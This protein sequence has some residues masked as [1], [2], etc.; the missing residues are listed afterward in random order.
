MSLKTIVS[1]FIKT[2]K[3]P[4]AN[5]APIL[6]PLLKPLFSLLATIF[7]FFSNNSLSNLLVKSSTVES[8]ELLSTTIISLLEQLFNS[9]ATVFCV[10]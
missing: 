1:G 6:F 10:N 7:N 3:S 9:D 8:A 4:C 2:K 5:D